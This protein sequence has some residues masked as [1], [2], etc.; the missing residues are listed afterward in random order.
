MNK[1]RAAFIYIILVAFYPCQLLSYTTFFDPFYS[2]AS[3]RAFGLADAVTAEDGGGHGEPGISYYNPAGLGNHRGLNISTMVIENNDNYINADEFIDTWKYLFIEGSMQI[4]PDF[5]IGLS[6][7][8]H[9]LGTLNY[10]DEN[11]NHLGEQN[12]SVNRIMLSSAYKS[13]RK[14]FLAGINFKFDFSAGEDVIPNMIDIDLGAIFELITILNVGVVLK[15][16]IY[17]IRTGNGPEGAIGT[18]WH[19]IVKNDIIQLLF[20]IN[21]NQNN[22]TYLINYNLGLK[23]NPSQPDSPLKF[24]PVIGLKL[25]DW[26]NKFNTKFT[27]AFQA[28][29]FGCGVLYKFASKN[30]VRLDIASSYS[31]K[32]T[33]ELGWFKDI[34]VLLSFKL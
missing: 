27:G 13:K 33:Q 4:K 10:Y 6:Y 12:I 32:G 9:S 15:N 3:A 34:F 8:V 1:K 29:T 11:A 21:V 18:K 24:F 30:I 20:D 17:W 7:F 19:N 2:G 31:L 22:N 23:F 5:N 28:F 14:Y 25:S 26:N 16:P